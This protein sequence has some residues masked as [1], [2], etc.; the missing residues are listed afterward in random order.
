MVSTEA[1]AAVGEAPSDA[2]EPAGRARTD[3]AAAPGTSPLSSSSSSTGVA[4]ALVTAA[5]ADQPTATDA[6]LAGADDGGSEADA[7][8]EEVDDEALMMDLNTNA[9]LTATVTGSAASTSLIPRGPPPV[10]A[11]VLGSAS[12]ALPPLSTTSG[13]VFLSSSING[14]VMI[15]DRR[16]QEGNGM[17]RA[18]PKSGAAGGGCWCASVSGGMLIFCLN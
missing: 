17:V 15:W 12:D 2:A 13:D 8:G 5:A 18:L 1:P 16:V 6:P 3:E 9:T 11:P 10:K 4:A 14:E 7:D